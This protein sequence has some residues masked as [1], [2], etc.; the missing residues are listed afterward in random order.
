MDFAG[1]AAGSATTDLAP[2]MGGRY[3]RRPE[4]GVLSN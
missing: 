2:K 3:H 1:R 4:S